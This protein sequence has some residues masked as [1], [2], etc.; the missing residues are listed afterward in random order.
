MIAQEKLIT[1][2]PD[3]KENEVYI[4]HVSDGEYPFNIFGGV[5][6]DL[7][8]FLCALAENQ[9]C[10]LNDFYFR[11]YNNKYYDIS[12]KYYDTFESTMCLY[13]VG[14]ITIE[15]INPVILNIGM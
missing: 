10:T 1:K 8:L 9:K 15:K 3:L 14:Y 13:K 6:T 5:Y 7:N 11:G 12:L 2:I 4:S